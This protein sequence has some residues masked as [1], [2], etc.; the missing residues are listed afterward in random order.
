MLIEFDC[1][2]ASGIYETRCNK[3]V[4]NL[5]TSLKPR[6]R[7]QEISIFF[8]DRIDR[9]RIVCGSFA[10]IKPFL[11]FDA[12]TGRALTRLHE[13][14]ATYSRLLRSWEPSSRS[15]PDESHSLQHTMLL[16]RTYD[17]THTRAHTRTHKKKDYFFPRVR[18]K[19]RTR[20]IV[21]NDAL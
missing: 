2:E 19:R 4:R 13:L 3:I 14:K 12:N 17:Q 21:S 6:T 7:V 11:S 1:I 9:L 8:I 10:T 15:I 5:K 20:L 16:R 18:L